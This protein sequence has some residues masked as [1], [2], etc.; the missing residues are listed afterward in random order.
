MHCN[1]YTYLYWLAAKDT[2]EN[3]AEE[4]GQVHLGFVPSLM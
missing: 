4:E 3:T 2:N 1:A